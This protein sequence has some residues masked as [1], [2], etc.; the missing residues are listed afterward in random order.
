M[1]ERACSRRRRN[2]HRSF[3]ISPSHHL[4][5]TNQQLL[6]AFQQLRQQRRIFIHVT[7]VLRQVASLMAQRE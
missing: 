4:L 3:N 2:N 7:F 5:N 1:W 6:S